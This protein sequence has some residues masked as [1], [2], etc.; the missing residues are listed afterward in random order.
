MHLA[1]RCA[2]D[3]RAKLTPH[4]WGRLDMRLHPLFLSHSSVAEISV[5]AERTKSSYYCFSNKKILDLT[6]GIKIKYNIHTLFYDTEKQQTA[7]F[8]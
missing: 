5:I 4:W 1:S 6:M 7:V 3:D 2:K 8:E